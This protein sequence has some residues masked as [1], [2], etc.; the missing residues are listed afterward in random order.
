MLKDKIESQCNNDIESY[1][2]GIPCNECLQRYTICCF[3]YARCPGPTHT[4]CCFTIGHV[5]S[6]NW[7]FSRIIYISGL[8]YLVYEVNCLTEKAYS[9][10]NRTNDPSNMNGHICVNSA[11]NELLSTTIRSNTIYMKK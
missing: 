6:S 10:Y 4:T 3:I 7:R 9:K 2:N 11:R 5:N 8:Q 1:S